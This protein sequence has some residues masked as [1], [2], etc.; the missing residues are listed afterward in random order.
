M[1]LKKYALLA[2]ALL[3]VSGAVLIGCTQ[4]S[5]NSGNKQGIAAN[6]EKANTQADENI[7]LAEAAAANVTITGIE[8]K[9]NELFAPITVHIGSTS[10]TYQWENVSNADY[11]PELIV[12]DLDLDGKEE[13]YLFTVKGYGTGVLN[14]EAHIMNMDFTEIAAPNPNKD[15]KSKLS[16]SVVEKNGQQVYTIQFNANT[17]TFAFQ[18]DAAAMW[19][20]EAAVGKVTSY[21]IED[22]RL[23]VSQSLQVSPSIFVGTLDTSYRLDN[24]Q[25]KLDDSTFIKIDPQ[26]ENNTSTNAKP[27]GKAAE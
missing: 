8:Q 15:L 22:H 11:Y 20:E 4:T 12:T 9:N 26:A 16:S 24:G 19:F 6:V 3:C 25:F 13:V 27:A 5:S 1:S 21:R 23:I 10:K 17:Y 2:L 7:V 14:S 18:I